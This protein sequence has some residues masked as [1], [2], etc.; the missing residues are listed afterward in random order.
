MTAT[1][2]ADETPPIRMINFLWMAGAFA[3]LAIVIALDNVWLLNFVHVMAG[4]LWT[5]IDL[6]MGFVVGP[7]MRRLP[8]PARRAFIVRLTP[9]TVFLMPTL[10]ILT[11]TAGWFHARQIG[12]L[13]APYPGFYWVIAALAI[14]AALNDS[15]ARLPAADQSAGLSGNA[16]TPTGRRQS[17]PLDALVFPR[18]RRTGSDA[19]RHHPGHGQVRHRPVTPGAGDCA[20]RRLVGRRRVFAWAPTQRRSSPRPPRR[21]HGRDRRGCRRCA[22][23]RSTGARSL[24]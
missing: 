23:C 2:T 24:R 3:G 20:S 1:L 12:L 7:L 16:Q 22:R 15:G 13:G 19:G 10:A 18:R 4:V 17:R 21:A 11:G 9:K 6:F 14:V 8:I 5:G